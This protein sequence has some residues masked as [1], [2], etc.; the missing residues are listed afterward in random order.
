METIALW[1]GR[2]VPRIGV[3]CWAIGGDVLAGT[4][5]TGY[6][7]VDDRASLRGL[8]VADEMGAKLFDTAA[9]YGGG[10]SERLLGEAFGGRADIVIV[11]K[12]GTEV[13]P[14]TRTEK[15]MDLSPA[16]IRASVERSR[17]N[18]RRDTIDLLL[19]HINR[20]PPEKSGEV[21][22]T[23]EALRAE[24]KIA[25][26]GWSNDAVEGVRAVAGRPGFVAIENDFNLFMPAIELMAYAEARK[27]IAI[28][29]LPLAMGMLTGKYS[30][31][32][33]VADNDVRSQPLDWITFFKGGTANPRY[34][35]E[36]EKIR[37]LLTS[38]GRTLAQGALAW[39]L[40]R[41]P[42]ALPVPGFKTET[43]VR[44]NLGAL[45]KGPLPP[46]T[47]AEIERIIRPKG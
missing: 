23:L 3:G 1:D 18:L 4:N 22:D 38:G 17:K 46:E 11:T 40:A 10:H 41:S 5:H 16:A 7:D 29:R 42:V 20:H 37:G 33:K 31:G 45:E 25:S 26:F 34:V 13:D 27:L 15:R 47:M 30:A 12:F 32:L 2:S 39:I 14:Q 6:G 24:N 28:S 36:L 35:A 19:F 43:Q 8:R 21:F 44:D 9:Y